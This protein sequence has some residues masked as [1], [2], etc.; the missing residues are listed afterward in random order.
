M[1]QIILLGLASSICF[2]SIAQPTND[3]SEIDTTSST[4][5]TNN[6]QN[7]SYNGYSSGINNIY[8][9]HNNEDRSTNQISSFGFQNELRRIKNLSNSYSQKL[10]SKRLLST[11]ALNVRQIA[12]LCNMLRGYAK[13]DVAQYAYTRCKDPFNYDLVFNALKYDMRDELNDYINYIDGL[14]TSYDEDGEDTYGLYN[15]DYGAM[16]KETFSSAKQTI[17]NAS[18]ENTKLETAKSIITNNKV[19]TDQVIEF[20][21]LFS[22]D[23]TRLDFAEFAYDYCVDKRKYFK[24]NDVF[25]FDA[26]RTK[27]NQ[28]IQ[29]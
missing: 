7:R 22:F 4:T 20:C 25:D 8:K 10:A 15:N 16:S 24:V 18:F 13:L 6:N 19:T 9:K 12:G 5:V 3:F 2:F 28:F 26:S 23:A 17:E 27:L 14:Y 29:H 11:Y 21:R 1:K